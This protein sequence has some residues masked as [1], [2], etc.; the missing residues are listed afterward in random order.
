MLDILGHGKSDSPQD[1]LRYSIEQVAADLKEILKKLKIKKTHI[2]GYS[3]GGRLALTFAVR[4][5][6]NVSSLILES[7]SPGLEKRIKKD[8]AL[9][10]FIVKEG[11]EVFVDYWQKLPLFFTQQSLPINTR[12]TIRNQRLNNN[13]IGLANSLRGMGTG[14][15]PSWWDYLNLLNIPIYIMVGEKD[16]KFCQIANKMIKKLPNAKTMIVEKTGHAIHVENQDFFGK[17]IIDFLKDL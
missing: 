13:T 10:N 12:E 11:V 6:Q 2:L 14:K 9:A 5:P 15:Q 17:M 1:P 4:Y 7:S 8:E 16:A 3:M